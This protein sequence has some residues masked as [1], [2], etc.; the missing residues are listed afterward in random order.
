MKHT[1]SLVGL[2][3]L[4]V[5]LILGCGQPEEPAKAQKPAAQPQKAAEKKPAAESKPAAEPKAAGRE[6]FATRPASR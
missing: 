6:C 1:L 4:S 5:T 3:L 2:A